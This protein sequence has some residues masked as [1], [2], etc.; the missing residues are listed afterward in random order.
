MNDPR[1]LPRINDGIA[2][3]RSFEERV[4][5]PDSFTSSLGYLV[6]AFA[7]L[8]LAASRYLASLIGPKEE[9]GVAVTAELSF[10][11]K[12]HLLSSLVR[13]RADDVYMNGGRPDP[14]GRFAEIAPL[15]FRAEELRNILLHSFW[16]SI[17]L[18]PEM[19]LRFKRSAKAKHGLKVSLESLD[20]DTILDVADYIEESTRAL[21]MFFMPR[22]WVPT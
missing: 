9:V 3:G 12:V 10:A 7:A 5:A 6:L 17:P 19:M 22:P 14:S 13:L 15:C 18:E 8:E 16:E 11:N 1:R 4:G 20:S 21:D 2:S